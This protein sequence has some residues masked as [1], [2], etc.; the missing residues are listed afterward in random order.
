[1]STQC[2]FRKKHEHVYIFADSIGLS[3]KLRVIQNTRA[4]ECRP[5]RTPRLGLVNESFS[6]RCTIESRLMNKTGPGEVVALR[7]RL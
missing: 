5:T 2:H 4:N 3:L 7:T 1:M 6:C